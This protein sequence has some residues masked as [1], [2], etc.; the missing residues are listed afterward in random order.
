ML[1]TLFVFYDYDGWMFL[2]QGSTVTG[3][4][5]KILAKHDDA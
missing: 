2:L 5:I 4:Y 3:K 1:I